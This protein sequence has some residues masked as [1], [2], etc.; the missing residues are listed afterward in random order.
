MRGI[1]LG[2]LAAL[3][4][5]ANLVRSVEWLN[6]ASRGRWAP[7]AIA[8]GAGGILVGM[9]RR[10]DARAATITACIAVLLAVWG[11]YA[12]FRLRIH[13]LFVERSIA[14]VVVADLARLFA[15]TVPAAIAG[16]MTA[17]GVSRSLSSRTASTDSR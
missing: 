8:G 13:V 17:V 7:F 12:T 14:R 3:L 1:A 4:P 6:L 16:A 9:L 5:A 10:D 11:I 2:F 15:Y